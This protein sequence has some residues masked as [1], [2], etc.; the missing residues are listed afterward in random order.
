MTTVFTGDIVYVVRILGNGGQSNTKSWI[1]AFE[2]MAALEPVHV[3]PGHGRA[4]TLE[5]A[6]VDTYDYLV[7]RKLPPETALPDR[8]LI[9]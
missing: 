1:E 5:P 6:T 2:A 4:T 7:N 8:C 9:S 3:V